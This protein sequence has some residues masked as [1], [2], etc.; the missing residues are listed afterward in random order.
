MIEFM[1]SLDVLYDFGKNFT[2]RVL[3]KSQFHDNFVKFTVNS[4][5][6]TYKSKKWEIKRLK[7]YKVFRSKEMFT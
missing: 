7:F 1:M 4:N 6:Q 3:I 2:F 5:I